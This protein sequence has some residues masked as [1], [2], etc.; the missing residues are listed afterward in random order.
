MR[1]KEPNREEDIFYDYFKNNLENYQSL[2]DEKCWDN[3]S[4]RIGS[5]KRNIL[6]PFLYPGIAA[7]ILL[8]LIYVL[9]INESQYEL[10]AP[11]KAEVKMM[12]TIDCR[13]IANSAKPY[14]R[15]NNKIILDDFIGKKNVYNKIGKD[16]TFSHKEI[17]ES[18]E[19]IAHHADKKYNTAE[20]TVKTIE[21]SIPK[22]VIIDNLNMYIGN[23]NLILAYE[24]QRK[25]NKWELGASLRAS[26]VQSNS[27]GENLLASSDPPGCG[28]DPMPGFNAISDVEYAPPFSIGVQVSKKLNNILR[29]ET[30]LTY[31]YLSTSYKDI[32]K[33]YYSAELKLHYIGIPV[34]LVANIYNITPQWKL[35]AGAGVMLEK[36]IRSDFSQ[37]VYETKKTIT[38]E[39]SIKGLQWSLSASIGLSYKFH[40][41]WN[42][43]LD[44][45]VSYYF[46][47]NQPLSIRTEKQ[48][49][50][51]V[52]T[53][54][55]YEF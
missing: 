11:Y 32:D 15:L 48:T 21:D 47:N 22:K 27:S 44:P 24:P 28:A 3:I 35:Y 46:D 16:A 8:I 4:E 23:D 52:N 5:K 55:R 39:E 54:F 10:L 36:G 2:V 17:D 25:N 34:N 12:N 38:Q 18:K 51:G 50:V 49:M 41:G 29:L 33:Q 6:R 1:N 20:E 7:A 45:H 26:I 40:K 9:K 42:L 37:Y 30:G 31:S 13:S 19:E 53:G 14:N 43:Y